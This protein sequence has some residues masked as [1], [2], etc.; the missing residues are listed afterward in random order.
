MHMYIN[1]YQQKFLTLL[2]FSCMYI[3]IQL[4]ILILVENNTKRTCIYIIFS[5]D[6]CAYH[7]LVVLALIYVHVHVIFSTNYNNCNVIFSIPTVH[8]YLCI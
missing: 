4:L 2:T 7:E 3:I 1:F 6:S 5:I 8:V